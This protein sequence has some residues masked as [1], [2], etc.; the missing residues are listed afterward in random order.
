[1]TRTSNI[2]VIA[3]ATFRESVRGKQLVSVLFIAI[4]LVVAAMCFGFVTIGDQ[5]RVV[6]D[7][8]LF[9]ASISVAAYASITGS[10]FLDKEITRRTLYNI[11]SKDVSRAEFLI[12]KWL[13]L[14]L[15]AV[16]LS[17]AL[18]LT[19][20]ILARLF[21]ESF[22]P[23]LLTAFAYGILEL[24][25]VCSF[26]IFFSAIV[27]TP[28]LSGLFTFGLFLAGRSAN[29]FLYFVE[30]KET[31]E[32]VTTLLKVCYWGLPNL[33]QINVA[34]GIVFGEAPTWAHF[35]YGA[36]YALSYTCLL[37]LSSCILF[38]KR[39]FL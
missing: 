26:A 3:R 16:V 22:D 30:R 6:K 32:P 24:A 5:A 21:S 11:L 14:V 28:S 7:F 27:V 23:L 15:S 31:V 29:Y 10:S 18:F 36:T 19:T 25:L 20:V 17:S 38:S 1:M 34:N 39:N 2:G 37:L 9:A 13:G 4:A 12:G 33:A 8:G 35:A